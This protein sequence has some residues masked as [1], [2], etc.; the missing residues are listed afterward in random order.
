MPSDSELLISIFRSEK[1]MGLLVQS[2]FAKSD[3]D[4]IWFENPIAQ[5]DRFWPKILRD[6]GPISDDSTHRIIKAKS[7][8]G[9]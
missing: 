9:L 6:F 1:R 5:V 7:G 3:G 4:K 8:I 2:D